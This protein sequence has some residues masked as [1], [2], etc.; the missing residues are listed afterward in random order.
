MCEDSEKIEQ[1][2]SVVEERIHHAEDRIFA[3]LCKK[4]KVENVRELEARQ[5]K[6]AQETNQRRAEFATQK[7]KIEMQLDLLRDRRKTTEESLARIKAAIAEDREALDKLDE[8]RNGKVEELEAV[9]TEISA[10]NEQLKDLRATYDVRSNLVNE[11]KRAANSK[12]KE[13]DAIFKRI[14][15]KESGVEKLNNER[16]STFQRCKLEGIRLPLA[17]GSLNDLPLQYTQGQAQDDSMDID[18]ETENRSAA[19]ALDGVRVDFT[20]LAK[21]H[22]RVSLQLK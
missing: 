18:G 6:A 12:Q 11:F 17:E 21:E 15:D 5:G 16:F 19:V 3:P 10:L 14:A 2:I 1:E 7:A 9:E 13:V 8:D 22:R 4:L 20:S